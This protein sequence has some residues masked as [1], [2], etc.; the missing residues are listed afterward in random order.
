MTRL[1]PTLRKKEYE[2]R[3]SKLRQKTLET[4]RKREDLIE[5][6]KIINGSDQVKWKNMPERIVQ[7]DVDGSA[8]RNLRRGGVYVFTESPRIYVR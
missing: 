2:Y 6:Y 5:F 1:V 3:L 7:G 8:A 4:R